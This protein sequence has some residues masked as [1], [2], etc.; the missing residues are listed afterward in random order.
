MYLL[1]ENRIA[2]AALGQKLAVSEA[3]L[4]AARVE[5][6]KLEDA[7]DGLQVRIPVSQIQS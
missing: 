5:I 4:T 7:Q 6:S 1:Q 2:V 3:E